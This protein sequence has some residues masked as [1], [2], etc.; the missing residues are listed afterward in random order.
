MG[1]VTPIAV[2]PNVLA[3]F[4]VYPNALAHV[5]KSTRPPYTKIVL[6]ERGS[7]NKASSVP[8]PSF[9][10]AN[11]TIG[12]VWRPEYVK[13]KRFAVATKGIIH[14]KVILTLV[15]SGDR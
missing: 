9:P 10:F 6:I 3:S 2:N 15:G 4:G 14:L 5:T 13:Q 7:G 12:K 11:A 8:D 1:S